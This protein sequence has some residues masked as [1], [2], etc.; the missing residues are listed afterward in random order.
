MDEQSR[1]AALWQDRVERML[2]RHA[3]DP[4]LLR[5]DEWTAAAA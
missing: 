5:F 3:D 2:I 4:A 1:F